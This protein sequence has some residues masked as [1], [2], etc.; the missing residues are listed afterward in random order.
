MLKVIDVDK[1]ICQVAYFSACVLLFSQFSDY[2]DYEDLKLIDFGNLSN[3][4]ILLLVLRLSI[5]R[6][7]FLNPFT[8]WLSNI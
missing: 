8:M 6:L 7:H 2:L 3:H 5:H 1:L 4:H